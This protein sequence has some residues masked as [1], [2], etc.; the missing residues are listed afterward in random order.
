VKTELI[1][2]EIMNKLSSLNDK[3]NNT[4]GDKIT[5][6]L[7]D[8]LLVELELGRTVADIVYMG[9]KVDSALNDEYRQL[10]EKMITVLEGIHGAFK[11]EAISSA[12][13]TAVLKSIFSKTMIAKPPQV[14]DSVT[15]G[16]LRRTRTSGVKI[17]FLMGASQG[18]FPKSSAAGAGGAEFTENETEMLCTAGI[19]IDESR[20]DRYH[21]ERFLINRAMTLP[22]EKLIITAPLRDAAWKEK[23]LSN[24]ILRQ[25]QN[26]KKANELPLS[27][28]ASHETALKFLAAEKLHE[29]ALKRALEVTNPQE[30]QRLFL[31]KDCSYLHEINPKNAELLMKRESFSP[32]RIETL[33]TCLFKY[34]CAE[35]LQIS[36]ERAENSA[37]PDALTRGNMT[38]YVLEN[39]LR[40]YE[41]FMEINPAGFVNLAE[42]YIAEFEEKVF[43]S[44]GSRSRSS[45]Q[46]DILL[47]HAGGI[48]EVLKQMRE[49]FEQSDFKPVEF[50]KT[51]NFMLGGISI[52]GK[53]DRVDSAGNAVRVVDY[54]TGSKEFSYPEINFGLNL[55]A[56]IYLFATAGSNGNFKPSGAFYRLVNGG[57]LSRDYKP[58]DVRETADDLY[59]NRLETQKTT[60]LHFGEISSDIEII[61]NRMKQNSS[62]RKEFIK[63]ENLEAS[64][65]A[66]L[67]EKTALQLRERLRTLCSGDIRAVPVYSRNLPCEHCDYRNI[68]NNAG[69][70][71]EVRV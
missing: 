46:K 11:N 18:E 54:K 41:Y 25:K 7:A 51:F 60:G 57:R 50:E 21:R 8:F 69:K 43:G 45:R 35:G 22:A 37:E 33:N 1:R 6:A 13:Y 62:S 34:F 14:L 66:E 9:K 44:G 61:N 59:K 58:Y 17:V 26:I 10:W 65:F 4:T 68:C 52:K 64:Q 36:S 28:W 40:N 30:H 56:L 48:A 53:I 5:E 19:F 71:E 12:D 55:Q 20:A 16:D 23:P 31:R 24:L 29:H 3:I 15:I 47:A 49:D 32:S 39:V 27:F 70:R 67:A 38:H 42:K 2:E 63:L